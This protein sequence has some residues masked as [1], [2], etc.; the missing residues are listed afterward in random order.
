MLPHI[1][2]KSIIDRQFHSHRFPGMIPSLRRNASLWSMSCLN[3]LISLAR[4]KDEIE[5]IE[6]IRLRLSRCSQLSGSSFGLSGGNFR[7]E[8]LLW[9]VSFVWLFRNWNLGLVTQLGW[10]N[11]VSVGLGFSKWR[12]SS[13]M[14]WWTG[15]IE[16]QSLVEVDSRWTSV[17]CAK[18]LG[19][20][21]S[22][23]FWVEC[24][25]IIYLCTPYDISYI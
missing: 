10:R 1:K 23:I 7:G 16:G 18:A 6:A 3:C 2:F 21:W 15:W 9:S 4:L 20:F 12:R 24:Q 25:R 11:S 8:R 17:T 13:S 5:E 14:K 19:H 22:S